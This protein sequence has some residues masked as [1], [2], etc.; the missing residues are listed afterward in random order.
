MLH[1]RYGTPCRW[2]FARPSHS[3]S[4]RNFQKLTFSPG[5]FSEEMNLVLLTLNLVLLRLNLVLLRLN[6]V[7]LRLNLVLLRLNLV[8]L[9]LY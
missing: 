5:L 3:I 4:L 8:L 2:K 6:L 7:L 1:Q 9:R